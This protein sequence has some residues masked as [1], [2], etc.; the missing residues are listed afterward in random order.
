M[1]LEEVFVSEVL[2]LMTK[3]LPGF[4]PFTLL[5]NFVMYPLGVTSKW[6][7]ESREYLGLRPFL[8]GSQV[9]RVESREVPEGPQTVLGKISP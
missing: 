6:E 2:V 9:S 8:G 5:A 1:T 7:L 4:K 3:N